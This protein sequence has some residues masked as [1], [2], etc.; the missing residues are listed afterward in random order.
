[1]SAEQ[2]GIP[3][4]KQ[5][6]PQTNRGCGAACLSMVYRSFG[7]EVAQGEIWP[8]IAKPN[9][10]GS[11][12]STTHLMAQDAMNRGLSAVAIQA[13]HPLQALRLCR[14]GGLRAILNHRL[15][16]DA[17]TGHY[18]VLVD[19]DGKDVVLHDPFFGPSRRLS[20]GDLLD[21]WQPRFAN[22][23]IVGNA[24]IVVA[25][26]P[27]LAPV[28]E[29]CHTP[30][31]PNVECP[32]CHKP[33]GL[34]PGT[35]LGCMN[36]G[37]IARMWNYIC[38]PYCD[39]TWTFSLQPP[40]RGEFAA[41]SAGSSSPGARQTPDAPAASRSEQDP[42]NLGLFLGAMDT[43]C[44]QILAVPTAA[45]HPEIK[46]QIGLLQASKEQLKIAQAE[47]LAYQKLRE[48]KISAA[49]QAARQKQEAHRQRV[50]ELNS[51]SPPLD[52]NA[53]GRALLKNLG[54]TA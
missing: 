18:S 24:L 6:D 53:L 33:V 21:L 38:C 47:E 39:Y 12:A 34:R 50:A 48:E 40:H 9:R 51:Q 28:C 10:F 20:H 25:A 14:D 4:E 46:R 31:P 32:Q 17:P 37:C 2:T 45:N 41:A 52:G 30:I 1:M 26:G 35:M 42:W 5:S 7:K 15:Q 43:F 29:F 13:R 36:N 49:A 8:A 23:E 54:F 27:A 19:I 11:V 22:S 44:S 3:Y 16:P